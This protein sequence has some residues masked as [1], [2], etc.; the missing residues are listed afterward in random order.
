MQQLNKNKA[1]KRQQTLPLAFIIMQFYDK[2]HKP[3]ASPHVVIANA[4]GVQYAAV[5]DDKVK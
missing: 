1:V 3:V 4:A 5:Y 2:D